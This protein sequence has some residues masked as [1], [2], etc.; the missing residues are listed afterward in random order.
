MQEMMKN[1][2]FISVVALAIVGVVGASFADYFGRTQ[3]LGGIGFGTGRTSIVLTI[4]II[5]FV[6]YLTFTRKDIKSEKR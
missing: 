1:K 4:L 5:L 6:A 2:L 3:D